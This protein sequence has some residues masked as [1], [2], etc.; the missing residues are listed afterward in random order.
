MA[1]IRKWR[2]IDELEKFCR[3]MRTVTDGSIGF[4]KRTDDE[5]LDMLSIGLMNVR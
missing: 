3:K 4:F 5:D 2:L 1:V